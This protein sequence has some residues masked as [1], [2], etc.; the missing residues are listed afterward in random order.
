MDQED[1]KK[2]ATFTL[3]IELYQ[4]RLKVLDSL[5]EDSRVRLNFLRNAKTAKKSITW[6][7]ERYTFEYNLV[8]KSEEKN[9]VIKVLKLLH[10]PKPYKTPAAYQQKTA[11]PNNYNQN[12]EEEKRPSQKPQ[13]QVK[14]AV[15][16]QVQKKVR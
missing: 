5:F 9:T 6:N 7:E 11:Q 1:L 16:Q 14:P 13:K 12:L 4:W 15:K 2:V 8:S 10:V 3:D